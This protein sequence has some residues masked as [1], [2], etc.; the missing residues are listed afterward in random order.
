M[1]AKGLDAISA[2]TYLL[3]SASVGEVK[4]RGCTQRSVPNWTSANSSCIPPS[5]SENYMEPWSGDS[6]S[7]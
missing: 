5:V 7:M 2:A 6:L 3:T 1:L 4:R